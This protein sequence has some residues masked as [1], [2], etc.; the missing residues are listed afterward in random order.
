MLHK[1]GLLSEIAHLFNPRIS[2]AARGRQSRRRGA[3]RFDRLEALEIRDLLTV[4]LN[5]LTAPDM[6]AGKVMYVPLTGTDST[7]AAVSYD[8]TSSN[9]SV[10]ASVVSGG[11]S[12]KMTV[13]GKDSQG[14]TFT[15]DLTFRL[16]ESLEP[17][18]TARIID[19]VNSG[20]YNN[21]TFHRII[22]NFMIQGGD[23]S[24]NGTGGSGTTFSDEFNVNLTF[25]S[26]GL[27]AMANSGDDTNDSQFFVTD[28]DLSLAQ[29]PQHLNFDHTIFGILTSGF[30][31]Y[32]KIITTPVTGSTPNNQVKIT[33]ASVFTDTQN[34]VLRLSTP[35]DFTGTSTITVTATGAASATDSKT[36]NLNVVA[37]S[38]NDKPFL[39]PVQ[40]LTTQI[41]TAKTFT[42]N[43]FDLEKDAL[44]FI[45]SD[46][47][48]FA[49][50]QRYRFNP[51]EREREY[52]GH[53]AS[54]DTPAFATITLI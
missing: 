7:N 47:S 26:E 36:L 49:S 29:M 28:T 11:R 51:G 24:G 38:V 53:P 16:F 9:N 27:L 25:N 30:D 8:V 52:P 46:P 14:N 33:S 32:Q 43:G 44:T 35:S 39:G 12:I 3:R 22:N 40:N 10:T 18:T 6:P 31:T 50:R 45:V 41:N 1:T 48:T 15:G 2:G 21:L 13:T 54:G 34:G 4:S 5:T 42:V 19:L 37:D 23:P 20:F 17:T